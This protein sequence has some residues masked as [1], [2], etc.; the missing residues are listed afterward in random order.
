LIRGQL[1]AEDYEDAAAV[2][3][4][5]D[6]LRQKME[7]IENPDFSKNYLDQDKRSIGNSVQVFFRDGSATEKTVVEYPIGHPRRRKE[8]EPLLFEKFEKSLRSKISAENCDRILAL[9][10]DSPRLLS[11]PIDE[12]MDLFV[13]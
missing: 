2:D 1:T 4:R 10:A 13:V 5:I 12:L 11:T 9:F 6:A 3:P 8:G 7:V